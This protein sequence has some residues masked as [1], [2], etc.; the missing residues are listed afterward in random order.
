MRKK[1]KG[2]P[3]KTLYQPTEISEEL[4][5]DGFFPFD[6]YSRQNQDQDCHLNEID[7]LLTMGP[8]KKKQRVVENVT[9]DNCVEWLSENR[10][11]S[12]V[13]SD[14]VKP[15]TAQ[16]FYR[17]MAEIMP[18]LKALN[19]FALLGLSSISH[20]SQKDNGKKS[21]K[22][23]VLMQWHKSP[24]FNLSKDVKRLQSLLEN[25]FGLSQEDIFKNK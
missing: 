8:P 15:F 19:C 20:K 22:G 6:P 4:L 13:I 21:L 24:S 14:M 18:K 25:N 11:S 17:Y 10:N 1:E 9:V 7:G 16:E 5:K 12:I 3:K 23:T 2:P